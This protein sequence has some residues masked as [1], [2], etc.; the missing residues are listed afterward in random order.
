MRTTKRFTALVLARFHK[1]G[2]GKGTFKRYSAWHQVTRGD[3]AS[4]GRSHILFWMGRL[5]DLLSD[6]EWDEQLF[7][8]MLQ[9]LLD[10]LE[11]YPLALTDAPHPLAAY[12]HMPGH[13][14]CPGTKELAG[15]LGIKHPVIA[16]HGETT[17]WVMTTDLLLVLRGKD[18]QPELLA[19]AFK[20]A[21]KLTKRTKQLL[22]LE[23]E[24][25]LVRG[26]TW[27]LI[28]P[29][30]YDERVA[31]TLRRSEGW[32]LG[33]EAPASARSAA[34][35]VATALYWASLTTVLMRLRDQLGDLGSAQRAL[36]QAIWRGELPIDLTRGWRPHVP[37]KIVSPAQFAEFNPILSRR[38]AWMD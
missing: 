15:K 4:R 32:A 17:D 9:K 7:A 19:L 20:P 8:T 11:Q 6:G 3:P 25:W 22:R 28:T 16:E 12:V 33:D 34:V 2:R 30:L 13:V 35:A 24:Y 38:S 14:R 26:A 36:W 18:G 1:R 21:G 10:S 27:L 23:R 29:D 37:L 31:L 5:R